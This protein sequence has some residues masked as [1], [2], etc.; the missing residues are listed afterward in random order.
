M[1]SRGL[2]LPEAAAFK[3]A[4]V[5]VRRFSDLFPYLLVGA[6]ALVLLVLWLYWSQMLDLQS[7]SH[8]TD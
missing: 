5:P 3:G 1:H 6:A 4:V 7:L 8:L 2:E